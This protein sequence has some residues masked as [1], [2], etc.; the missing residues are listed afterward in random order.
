[1]LNKYFV[2]NYLHRKDANS[3]LFKGVPDIVFNTTVLS[4]LLEA[5]RHD[6]LQYASS[7]MIMDYLDLSED[8]R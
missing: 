4:K 3:K 1:M 5:P 2:S 7:A 8:S 6:I